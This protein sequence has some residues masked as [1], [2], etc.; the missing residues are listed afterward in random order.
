VSG[1]EI[2]TTFPTNAGWIGLL[3]SAQGLLKTTLPQKNQATALTELGNPVLTADLDDGYFQDLIRQFV[4]YFEGQRVI[5]EEKLDLAW[6]TAFE[7]AVWQTTCRIAYGQTRSY[8]WVAQEIQRPAACRA[9]G[10]V[11]G[12]NPL[13]IVVPCHRVIASDGTLRGF[14]GGLPMKRFLLDLEAKQIPS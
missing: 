3:A 7:K 9:V 1:K 13:P 5:F 6:S 14:G 11:L 4:R 10:Q 8:G 12:R 2:Y